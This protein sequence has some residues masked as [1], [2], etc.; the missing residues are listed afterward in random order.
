MKVIGIIVQTRIIKE[1]A[2]LNEKVIN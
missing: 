1:H 2:Q